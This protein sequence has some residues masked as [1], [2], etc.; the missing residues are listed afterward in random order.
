MEYDMD[1]QWRLGAHHQLPDA[2]SRLPRF[3]EPGGDIDDSF[4]DETP[5]KGAY[6][7]PTGP[8][9][10][11]IPLSELGV[12]EVD[13][14]ATENIAAAAGVTFTP[15]KPQPQTTRQSADEDKAAWWRDLTPYELP[16]AVV[17]CCG[18]GRVACSQQKG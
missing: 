1:L 18:G 9:L 12:D 3:E 7:G 10:D 5:N 17:L 15:D 11:G 2:L 4:L 6:Q 14:S 16:T 13:T 8:V